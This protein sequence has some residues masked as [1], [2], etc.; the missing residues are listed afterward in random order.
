MKYIIQTGNLIFYRFCDIFYENWARVLD[1]PI[2][3]QWKE[4]LDEKS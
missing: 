4:S 3:D 2:M 1:S